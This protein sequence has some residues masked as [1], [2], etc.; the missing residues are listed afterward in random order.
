MKTII[1]ILLCCIVASAQSSEELRKKYGAPTSE[2][3]S[4]VYLARRSEDI[5]KPSVVVTATYSKS[6]ELCSMRV[7][8]FPI[9]KPVVESTKEESEL[10]TK[11][12]HEVVDEVS[13]K[14]KRGKYLMGSFINLA[15]L[16][17]DGCFGTLERYEK[18][19]IY[20]NGNEHRYAE[21][22]WK[23]S[24]ACK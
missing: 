7:E 14:E 18:A 1:F 17:D 8:I 2:T 3:Y 12:L 22:T 6:K 23:N 4:E 16:P 13:P 24:V 9:F 10:K 20:Y 11:L 21:I 15:C 5:M 19:S